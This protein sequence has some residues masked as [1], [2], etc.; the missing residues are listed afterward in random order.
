MWPSVAIP[1]RHFLWASARSAPPT[2]ALLSGSMA[3][4]QISHLLPEFPACPC[5][6]EVT[7]LVCRCLQVVATDRGSLAPRPAPQL[8]CPCSKAEWLTQEQLRHWPCPG[9]LLVVTAGWDA[10]PQFAGPRTAPQRDRAPT[11]T[12]PRGEPALNET[13]HLLPASLPFQA[14]PVSSRTPGLQAWPP[15]SSRKN[16]TASPVTGGA[17]QPPGRVGPVPVFKMP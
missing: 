10:T 9:T 16:S 15:S 13:P 14:Y 7:S 3:P 17:P 1:A 4:A 11:S 6:P 2:S 8:Q 12:V 5:T